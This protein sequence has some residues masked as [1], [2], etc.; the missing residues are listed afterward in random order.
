MTVFVS[1]R[2]AGV[3]LALSVCLIGLLTSC[4]SAPA[5]TPTTLLPTLEPTSA[6]VSPAT[7][8]ATQSTAVAGAASTGVATSNA[9]PTSTPILGPTQ[10]PAGGNPGPEAPSG[11]EPSQG[12]PGS[13]V[14]V[15]PTFTNSASGNATTNP[16][17][18][19]Q[20]SSQVTVNA[21]NTAAA[22][23]AAAETGQIDPCALLAQ[24]D[25]EKIVGVQLREPVRS[26]AEDGA[27]TCQYLGTETNS[28]SVGIVL[29]EGNQEIASVQKIISE[30]QP[31]PV[32]GL[33]DQALMIRNGLIVRSGNLYVSVAV[34][35]A[36]QPDKSMEIARTLAEQ[37]VLRLTLAT[38]AATAATR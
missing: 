32:S 3:F 5:L 8:A 34:A 29:Y 30:A 12:Q 23:S 2:R 11:G 4:T 1:M 28:I 19:T 15:A 18:G 21:A 10:G 38:P 24:A 36:N 27:A 25:I 13:S 17:S 37:V 9:V 16:V 14:G 26:I 7:G 35:I 6:L 20:P 33:G 31:T 22:T